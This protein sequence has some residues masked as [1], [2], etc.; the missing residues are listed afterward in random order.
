MPRQARL[1][2][3]GVLQHIMARGI[4][5]RKIFWDDKD[6]SSF[7]ERLAA[8]LEETQTQC[9]A[10]ALIPNH[11]H[12][13][14][15]TGTTPLSTVMRRLMTGYAVTFNIRHRRSGHLF[16][17]RYKSVV[18]EEDPYLLELIRY[19]HLNPLRAG[20]VNDLKELDKY[21]WTGHRAILGRCKNPL[22]PEVRN[23]KSGMRNQRTPSQS[24]QPDSPKQH[25]APGTMRSASIKPLA[26]KTIEYVLLHF[27]ETKRVARRRYREFVKNGIDQGKRPELQGGGLVRSAGGNK[28]GLLGR[29]KEERELSDERILGSGDFVVQA[30]KGANELHERSIKSRI[31]LNEL[32][33]RVSTDRNIDLKELISSKRKK[34][35]SNTRAIIS[36]LAA[37]ELRHSGAKIASELRLSEKSVSRCIERGRK[38][39]DND[40]KLLEYLQ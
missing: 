28:A 12:L 17:N 31:S 14:L 27:G 36:Y 20:L 26:E 1:D 7:L 8:I 16:Q 3:P 39:V 5:R 30:L 9:Y 11:F 24:D 34:D 13:L 25:S 23:L 32:I 38:L 6:R 18:C 21:P 33:K 15:R 4:E 35:I 2:A 37:I 40:K 22:V 10:W 29:K 19:I